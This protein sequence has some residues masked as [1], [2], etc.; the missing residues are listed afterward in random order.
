ME[1]NQEHNFSK[2]VEINRFKLPECCAEQASLYHFW[3]E[4]QADARIAVK[5][6]EG[7][8]KLTEAERD[9]F[10]RE[11]KNF[12]EGIKSTEASI[13]ALI[14]SDDEV[15]VAK[16]AL[17]QAR[18]VLYKLDAGV[19][20]LEHRRSELSNLTELYA[21]A[22]YANPNGG[23]STNTDKG[24]AEARTGLNKDTPGS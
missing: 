12:P 23:N 22:F 9:L 5:G 13:K 15:Q 6:A 2:D 1:N 8:V 11:P 24:T 18:T 3:A 17:L 14:E 4:K 10:Y 19:T 16:Q 20:A 21:K 7:K